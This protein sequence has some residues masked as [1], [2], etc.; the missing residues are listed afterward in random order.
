[1]AYKTPWVND[2]GLCD[3]R[4]QGHASHYARQLRLL[5]NISW[6]WEAQDGL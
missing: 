1:M 5:G 2:G 6:H 3:D 4:S